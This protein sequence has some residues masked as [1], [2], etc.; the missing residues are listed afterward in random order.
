MHLS[1]TAKPLCVGL[2]IFVGENCQ[3]PS[4]VHC[5]ME[6][7]PSC[8]ELSGKRGVGGG[9]VGEAIQGVRKGMCKLELW[10]FMEWY[11]VSKAKEDEKNVVKS[12]SFAISPYWLKA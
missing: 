1:F 7:R 2:T 5:E 4:W 6:Q 12:F 10:G 3:C 9:R 8:P 11:R